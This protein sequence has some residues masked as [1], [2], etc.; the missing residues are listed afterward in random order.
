[1]HFKG[2]W[3]EH[4]LI[5]LSFP[6]KTKSPCHY[7]LILLAGSYCAPALISCA[8]KS[9]PR[10]LSHLCHVRT[11]HCRQRRLNARL[12][13]EDNQTLTISHCCKPYKV[14]NT[15]YHIQQDTITLLTNYVRWRSTVA[16]DAMARTLTTWS[17]L[18][19]FSYTLGDASQSLQRTQ[20][21]KNK[22][23]TRIILLSRIQKLTVST[24][25]GGHFLP[26][27]T[28]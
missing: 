4:N 6:L 3:S 27:L 18:K 1:M 28:Q 20:P 7:A 25:N 12:V 22:D 8:Y 13:R 5:W 26:P 9:T 16:S 19:G 21:V 24:L 23:K 2:S 14:S 15:F 17:F 10:K 11:Y